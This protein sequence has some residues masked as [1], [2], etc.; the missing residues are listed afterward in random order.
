MHQKHD[1]SRT[2]LITSPKPYKST[3]LPL[4]LI[5]LAFSFCSLFKI[6]EIKRG[7]LNLTLL[8]NL[9]FSFVKEK[10]IFEFINI[11]GNIKLHGL[12]HGLLH[13]RACGR[14]QSCPVLCNPMDSSP[15][16]FSVHG[17]LQARMLEQVDISFS[18]T[19]FPP[20]DQTWVS[21]VAGS[22]ST[23]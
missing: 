5:F 2:D 19:S 9:Y 12:L 20:Q 17:I 6:V 16:G 7:F 10:A 23:N 11:H 15:P 21:C 3:S 1:F 4:G 22:F 14:A 18:R 13:W 8:M